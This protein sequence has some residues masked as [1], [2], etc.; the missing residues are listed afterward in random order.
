MAINEQSS[1]S[2]LSD[3]QLITRL[4]QLAQKEKETTLEIVRHLIEMDRRSLYLGRGYASLFEYCTRHLNYSESAAMRRIKTARCI[5]EFPEIYAMLSNS[6]LNLSTV[7]NLCGILTKENKRELLK[8]VSFKS[9]RQVA[10]IVARFSPMSVLHDRVRTVYVK[11]LVDA[12][13]NSDTSNPSGGDPVSAQ[14]TGSATETLGMTTCKSDKKFPADVGGR[15]LTTNN[16][17][18][19]PKTVLEQKFKLEFTVNPAFLKKLEDAKALLSRK[20]PRGMSFEQ[21]FEVVLD[22][23]LEKHSPKRKL[24]RR[25]K[26]KN[27]VTGKTKKSRTIAKPGKTNTSSNERSRHIPVDIQDKVFARDKGRCMYIGADGLR[28]NSTWNLQIDHIKPYAR[29]GDHTIR[30][31]R[32]LCAKHNKL[33]AERI[34]GIGMIKQ[35]IHELRPS[36]K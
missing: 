34:Y 4:D 16:K 23:Y 2:R 15:K 7:S 6:E 11:S 13:P 25:N 31:L 9:A 19:I 36:R 28:C 12:P 14:R 24:R 10:A 3:S 33:E 22:E 18:C 29:G 8:E 26:N 30:N 21:L 1:L 32:L 17:A 35:R 5:R 20:Y 27:K